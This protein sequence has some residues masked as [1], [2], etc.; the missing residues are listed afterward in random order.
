MAM[1]KHYVKVPV[2]LQMEEMEGGNACLTMVLTY[3]RKKVTLDQVRVACGISRN[4]IQTKDLIRAGN[5]FGLICKESSLA[6]AELN[7]NVKVPAILGWERN[8]Y[9]VLEG[10]R[11]GSAF[12][13][14]PTKGRLRVS[15][16]ELEKKYGGVCIELQPGKEFVSDGVKF[17]TTAFLKSAIKKDGRAMILVLLTGFLA[18]AGGIFTPVFS[19]IFTD[20]IL[21]G[22]RISWYPG[23]LYCFA[24]VIFLQFLAL[25]IHRILIIRATGKLAVRANADYMRHLLR[26]PMDFF[27]RRRAGDLANRQNTNDSIAET[28]IGELAP[29]LMNMIMLIFYLVV[30][31]QYSLPLTAI[32]VAT[33]VINLFVARRIGTI[34]REI[35]ATQYRSQANLDSATVS[36]IDMIESIKATGSE[37]GYF[38]RWS[39]FHASVNKAAVKFNEVAQY[40][41]MLPSF[42][43]DVSDYVVLFIG[44]WLIIRG[45]FTAG[46][47]LAFLQFLKSLMD[48]VN[49]LLEAGE[50]IQAMGSSLERIND[51]MDFKEEVDPDSD[52]EN[53]DF[54]EVRK[55]SGK[56]EVKNISF[57]Y[58]LYDEPLIENFNLELEPGKRVALVGGSGSGKS[59][60]AKMIAGLQ[61]PWSGEILFD[62]K[63]IDEI[64]RAVFKSSLTMVNQEIAL[65][66]DTMENNI[67]MW[68][69]TITS[70]EMKLAARDAKLHDF[71]MS[72]KDGYQTML[73]EGGKNLSGGER[74]RVEIA[75]VLATGPTILIMD[76]AT[77]ALDARTE[78][79]IS[80]YV[81]QRGIT[82]IIVA[83]RLSTIRDSDEIIVLDKG[84][85]VERGTHDELMARDGLYKKLIMTS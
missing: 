22:H 49:D 64:P 14:H 10:F 81:R 51:V 80:E 65:F 4:G 11:S 27:S 12:L 30:M 83:H 25:L 1:S 45:H 50:N 3:F 28:M 33:I 24:A 72:S 34:R 70:F 53:I 57:G 55:L 58:S 82:C 59:T 63:R 6:A 52:Y 78:Y 9:V 8:Q 47:L 39:G 40:L 38:E 60:I 44:F 17:G 54:S 32:G 5:S 42:L 69:D 68:D 18:A 67:K 36:G 31:V 75:R 7:K 19:R 56:V 85:V 20:D 62:G 13:I 74:Q 46:L 73:Q 48:P 29:L 77:S 37:A 15:S 43:Q 21:V 26:L 79:E 23:I 2:I 61:K 76:E 71:I 41:L 84:K 16:E 66:H 35:S